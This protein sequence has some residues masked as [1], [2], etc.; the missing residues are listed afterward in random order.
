MS[1]DQRRVRRLPP[2]SLCPRVPNVRCG[3]TRGRPFRR[4]ER[5]GETSSVETLYRS[6][7]PGS[8]NTRTTTSDT[9][10]RRHHT[11]LRD[12]LTQWVV[13]EGG[14]SRPST[15][16]SSEDPPTVSPVPETWSGGEGTKSA[17]RDPE[18]GRT[19]ATTPTKILGL[20]VLVSQGVFY[21]DKASRTEFVASPETVPSFRERTHSWTSAW[22][23]GLST[24]GTHRRKGHRPR[25]HPHTTRRTSRP[26]ERVRRGRLCVGLT[27]SEWFRT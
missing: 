21:P 8:L 10:R 5:R 11:S 2:P 18:S 9:R 12:R 14:P 22:R 1:S 6:R 23:T 26:R 25:A 15:P 4:R 7:F 16:V 24:G 13:T 3:A 19:H 20:E 27:R 17:E